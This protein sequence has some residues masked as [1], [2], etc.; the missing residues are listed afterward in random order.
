MAKVAL[1][2]GVSEYAEGLNPLLSAIKDI[3]A[4]RKVLQSPERGGFDEVKVLPNPEPTAMQEAVENLF[5]GRAKEDLALL[6][7]SGH[8]VKDDSGR[9]YFATSAT[10]KNPTGT[11]VKATAVP[12]SF[13]H[14][15]MGSSRC[16]RQ[17]VILDCCFSGAFA[18]G[19]TAKDDGTIDLQTQMGGEGRAVLTSS[20]STQYSFE[21]QGAELSVYT[22]FLVEGIETGAA[23]TDSDGW[24]SVDE[25]HD[26]A[27]KKVQEAAPA[28]KPKIY[29]VEEGFK[30]HLAKAPT[31]NPK[32]TYRKEVERFAS[33]GEISSIGRG[34]L[35][36]LQAQL[37]L[38]SEEAIAVEE[39]VLK[40]YQE[41]RKRLKQYEQV[42]VQEVKKNNPLTPEIRTDL[43]AFQES[44]GL[45]NEDIKPILARVT[46]REARRLEPKPS[47]LGSFKLAWVILFEE[48][49]LSVGWYWVAS[50]PS[51]SL[52]PS[53]SSSD[54]LP[55][56]SK[57]SSPILPPSL[58][59]SSSSPN[60]LPS[61]SK[62]SSPRM[63]DQTLVNGTGNNVVQGTGNN[64]VQGTGNNVVQGTGN[65]LTINKESDS[66]RV[67]NLSSCDFWFVLPQGSENSSQRW[68]DTS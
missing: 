27:R 56:S 39:E 11:L 2:I 4:M 28:M 16:K 43:V 51:L 46:P 21:Q 12:A 52:S 54:P 68:M 67:V 36:H 53:S 57:T 17:V 20:T 41:Y 19:M 58:S 40:P 50:H 18:E 49:S 37:G 44:L 60:P 64:V 25:L 9:L 48:L 7:F 35:S 45:R 59:P 66:S 29:A 63:G 5:S 55:N 22:R 34:A 13:L 24:T 42:L 8:G 14:D 15:I 6:F 23:D 61:S 3:E 1:L 30:I 65:Q 31:R 38:T 33:R 10:R 26:Y 32:L 47:R 62:T